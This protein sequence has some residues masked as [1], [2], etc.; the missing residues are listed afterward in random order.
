MELKLYT[1]YDNK[2]ASYGAPMYY[3]DENELKTA[4]QTFFIDA[5]TKPTINPIE[6]ELFE[7]GSYDTETALHTLLEKPTH[8]KNVKQMQHE[9]ISQLMTGRQLQQTQEQ[10]TEEASK[11]ISKA[12]LKLIEQEVN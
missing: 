5:L 8:I 10:E 4:M 2:V 6:H 11:K 1:I 7:L 3:K 12:Q 9:L